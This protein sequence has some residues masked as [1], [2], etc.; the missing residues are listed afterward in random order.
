MLPPADDPVYADW[1]GPCKVIAPTFESLA[2]KFAKPNRIA[3]AKVDVDNQREVAQQ[4]GVRA[5]P[6]FV[7]LRNGSVIDTIQGANPQALTAAVEKAVKLATGGGASF[8]TPGRT[9]ASSG[10]ESNGSSAPI[11]S[12]RVGA[13]STTG[14]GPI[15]GRAS[16]FDFRKIIN[17]LTMFFG[18]YITSLFSVGPSRPLT[19]RLSKLLTVQLDPYKSA[20]NS[21]YNAGQPSAPFRVSSGAAFGGRQFNPAGAAVCGAMGGPSGTGK[22]NSTSSS[23][24]RPSGSS[25]SGNSKSFKTLADLGSE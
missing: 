15:Q 23:S 17:F 14:G 7:I 22:V 9:L 18:L 21:K 10:G 20:Q 24:S 5:M 2:N 12:S 19:L 3:F 11:P 13:G 16:W 1:C 8:S 25:N 4:Y 6:T